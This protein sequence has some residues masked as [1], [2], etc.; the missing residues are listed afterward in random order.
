MFE[1]YLYLIRILYITVQIDD[2]KWIK[3]SVMER[4]YV[5]VIKYLEINQIFTLNNPLGFDKLLN[6]IIFVLTQT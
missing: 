6:Q 3:K 5:F 2:Y 1:N 4:I